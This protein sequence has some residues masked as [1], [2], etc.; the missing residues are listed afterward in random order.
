MKL[1]DVIGSAVASPLAPAAASVE[2]AALAYDN[3][4]VQPGTLFFCVPGFT[5]DGHD[6]APDAVARGASALVVERS[7]GLGVP[8]V[9][10]PSVRVAMAQ[11]AAR[12]NGDPSDEL[13]VVGVTGTNG[14]TTT[15]FLVR[16]LLEAAGRQ[17]GLLGTVTSIVGGE[18]REVQRT[19][20][21]AVELQAD[22]RAMLDGGDVAAAIEVSSHALEL[23][24]ADATR[25]AVAIFTNLTQDHLDFH[26]TMEEYFLAKRKLFLVESDA[27]AASAGV[28][29]VGTA[30][31]NLDDPY[32]RRLADELRAAGETPVTIAIDA[33]ADYRATELTTGLTGSTFTALTPEGPIA[34]RTPLPGRF[35]VQNVLGAIAAARALGV[36][37]PEIAQAL[38]Q[39]GRVPGRFE[40]VDEGQPFAVLV[41]YA[42]TPDSLDN[43]LQAARGL[44]EQRV[45]SVFGCGGDRD[46]TKRPLM[47][48]IAARLSDETYATSDNPRSEDPAAILAEVVVGTGTGPH[49]HVEVDRRKAI[50]DA[51]GAARAGDV[52]VIAGKGH[53]QGQEFEGGRKLP[54][55]DV[56]VAR[57]ALQALSTTANDGTA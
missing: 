25:F 18:Q 51:I 9:Q 54:F 55:D 30:V 19:T 11:F 47:G 39:A 24:R 22:L 23:H 46:R 36:S 7:L 5:R 33:D 1:L 38:P 20:A 48:E 13:Q 57:E 14:K 3:R 35:N 50:A 56:T 26:P 15:A 29:G 45:L 8:E 49:V 34:L 44:T 17:T 4:K 12:F 41:D 16:G 40:P 28:A 32:G 52:V 53:E 27:A 42:H 2:I 10:V 43:V 6:F 31:V 21:E 37:L